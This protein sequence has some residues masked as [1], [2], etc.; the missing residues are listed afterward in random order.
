M[1]E[2]STPLMRQYAAIKKEHPSALLLLFCRGERDLQF[3]RTPRIIKK[4]LVEIPQP[5]KSRAL[6]C[7]FLMAAYCRISGVEGSDMG[8]Q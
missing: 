4:E 5:N 8:N 7:F 6:G 3:A 1:S 2:P